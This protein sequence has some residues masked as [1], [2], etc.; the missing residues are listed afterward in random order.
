VKDLCG[1]KT[2]RDGRAAI[3]AIAKAEG[4]VCAIAG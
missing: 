3:D 1:M 2:A 4:A